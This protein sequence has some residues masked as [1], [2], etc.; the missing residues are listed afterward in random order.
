MQINLME[1]NLLRMIEKE[2]KNDK[3]QRELITNISH[4]LKT[5]LTIILGYLDIIRTKSYD[6]EDDVDKYINITYDKAVS[7]Q[8]LIMKLFDFVKL[9]DK[10]V[11]LNKSDVN[12]D[13][14]LRQVIM[15]YSTL[16]EEQKVTIKYKSPK[17]II[18]QSVDLDKICRVF[19]NL[20]NN[21]IKYAEKDKIV[22]VTLKK[23]DFGSLITFK[24]KCTKITEDDLDMLFNRFYRGD[25]A[26]NSSID[27]SGI[28]LSIVKRIVELHN[29]NIWSE[30]HDDEIWFIIRLRG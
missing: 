7:L 17:D 23:E 27:G 20:M 14:L 18:I 4:D 1:D 29:S 21:S 2:R 6:S 12:I 25:K 11:V 22:Q 19:N 10:E 9:S 24:N 5:P 13:K 3:I 16:A 15:D 8:K 26:R 30:L 28:G